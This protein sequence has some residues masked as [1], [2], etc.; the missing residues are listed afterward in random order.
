MKF[1]FQ[2]HFRWGGHPLGGG[3][4]AIPVA[5]PAPIP[6]AFLGPGLTPTP[7]Y[8]FILGPPLPPHTVSFSGLSKYPPPPHHSSPFGFIS[9][10]RAPGSAPGRPFGFIS[11][12]GPARVRAPH[13]SRAGCVYVCNGDEDDDDYSDNHHHH[14][15]R[16]PSKCPVVS[17]PSF[18]GP[19]FR[20]LFFRVQLSGNVFF[21]TQF[22][23]P[24]FMVRGWR[25]KGDAEGGAVGLVLGASW[26]PPGG[27]RGGSWGR[28]GPS[29]GGLGAS[30][31]VLGRPGAVLARL[32]A[33]VGLRFC[34]FS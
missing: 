6:V 11:C 3:V 17:G 33:H 22:F 10:P 12:P 13:G 2:L 14:E 7:P 34:G 28:L 8:G 16:T 25:A 32:W 23:N 30:W 26:G 5:F 4:R 20:P 24:S 29:W 9:G 1:H 31:G 18:S 15:P 21:R 19:V 27:S